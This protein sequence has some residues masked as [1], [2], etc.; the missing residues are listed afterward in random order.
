LFSLRGPRK[1][2]H[3]Q[4]KVKKDK[5]C[6]TGEKN[7]KGSFSVHVREDVIKPF[8]AKGGMGRHRKKRRIPRK[9]LREHELRGKTKALSGRLQQIKCLKEKQSQTSD[10]E[11][12][13]SRS[14]PCCKKRESGGFRWPRRE[15]AQN[16]N[17]AS[18]LL[19]TLTPK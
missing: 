13:R 4:K 12:S 17:V 11:Q 16:I 18:R 6:S 19:K 14:A 15:Q 2:T 3:L 7:K 9:R 5:I 8:S 10:F 1:T